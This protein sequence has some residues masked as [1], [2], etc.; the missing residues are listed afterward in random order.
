MS[1]NQNRLKKYIQTQKQTDFI[2]TYRHIGR[3][4]ESESHR[5]RDRERKSDKDRVSK[6]ER[7]TDS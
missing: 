1:I 3:E 4:R 7:Q 2:E 6:T 5:E